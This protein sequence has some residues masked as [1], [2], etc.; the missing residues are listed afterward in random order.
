MPWPRRL[1]LVLLMVV[2]AVCL[3]TTVAGAQ[4]LSPSDARQLTSTASKATQPVVQAVI[5]P[6]YFISGVFVPK[7]QLSSTL[8]EVASA[9]PVSHL[10]NALFKAF[11]PATTGPGIAGTDLLIVALWGLAALS[12]ALWR[13]SW[14]PRSA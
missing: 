1:L 8:R 9:F 14:S 7:N 11:D 4:S 10:N 2:G 12:I 6:L 5:L 3:S 13:F